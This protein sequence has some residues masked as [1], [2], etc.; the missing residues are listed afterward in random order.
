MQPTVKAHLEMI[1]AQLVDE[2]K[3]IL[4]IKGVT[5]NTDLLGKYTESMVKR[6]VHRVVHPMRVSTGAVIDYPI[7]DKLRQIDLIVW[8]PYPVPAIFEIDDFGLVPLSSA[9][10]V[11]EVKRSNY[12]GTDD[13]LESFVTDA[14]G[15]K[16][17]SAP[18][19]NFHLNRSAGLGLVCVLEKKPS[20]RLRALIESTD[21]IA[22]FERLKDGSVRLRPKDVL[23]L[24]NFLQFI[25]WT[26]R[27]AA[28]GPKPLMLD[29]SS[30]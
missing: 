27:G 14:K 10:G 19:V 12:Q 9:F 2:L 24:V 28:S 7:P 30:L 17:V 18:P 20:A 26:F 16:I 13:A 5:K 29:L 11:L 25:N 4:E 1:A 22:I 23:E 3:S 21:V 6:L 8:A 15:G